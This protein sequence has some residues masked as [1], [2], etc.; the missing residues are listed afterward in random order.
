MKPFE[1]KARPC[2][3]CG[4]LFVPRTTLHNICSPKCAYKD[5]RKQKAAE[6]AAA[7]ADLAETRKRKEKAMTR[8]E[9]HA[10]AQA[11]VNAYVR[12]RDADLP[13][14]SCGRHHEGQWHAGHYRSRGAAKHL[15]LDTRNIHKQCQPC[16]T[17]LHGNQINYRLGLIERYGLAYVEALECDNARRDLTSDEIDAI[18]REHKAKLKEMK[19][20]DAQ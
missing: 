5:L 11:A 8:S 15:A 6:K 2:K 9:R 10:R 13:C 1:P 18:W 4:Q 17:H 3:Q 14:I 16:N 12:A 20:W 7:K 19:K